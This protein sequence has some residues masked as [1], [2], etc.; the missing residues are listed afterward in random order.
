MK[1][2]HFTLDAS[3]LQSLEWD[4]PTAKLLI[5]TT[6][7]GHAYGPSEIFNIDHRRNNDELVA[8]RC[9][10]KIELSKYLSFCVSRFDCTTIDETTKT[11]KGKQVFLQR[12]K[13]N[14]QKERSRNRTRFL[15][16]EYPLARG[17]KVTLCFLV[18]S[19]TRYRRYLRD[20]AAS[21]DRK[22]TLMKKCIWCP[23]QM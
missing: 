10:Q 13:I 19:A 20:G 7:V 8:V 9:T 3:P 11:Q 2:K 21:P 4:Q 6:D 5:K 15:D 23:G 1:L 14:F 12:G 17:S 18:A 22:E 16:M